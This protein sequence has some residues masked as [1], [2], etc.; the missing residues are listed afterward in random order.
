LSEFSKPAVLVSEAAGRRDR[1][2]GRA[3]RARRCRG[4][5]SWSGP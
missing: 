4:R 1:A 3:A 2:D 5:S